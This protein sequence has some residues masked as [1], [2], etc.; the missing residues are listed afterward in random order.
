M[1]LYLGYLIP[2]AMNICPTERSYCSTLRFEL[3]G[4]LAACTPER[5]RSAKIF[6]KGIGYLIPWIFVGMKNQV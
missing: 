3:G 5:T 2:T 6:R 1:V 4:L